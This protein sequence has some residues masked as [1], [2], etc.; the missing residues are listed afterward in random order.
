MGELWLLLPC[1][2]RINRGSYVMKDLV[3]MSRKNDF[4]D[5][6]VV[7][8]HRGEPDGIIVCHLPFGPTAYFGLL[9]V[10]TRHDIR[11]GDAKLPNVSEAYP[12]LIVE[13]FSTKLGERT[14]NILRHLFPPLEKAPAETKR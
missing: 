1:S 9:N 6:V 10:V 14:A 7:H 12:H 2:Q 11:A 13:N 3:E 4:T 5:I 8:E